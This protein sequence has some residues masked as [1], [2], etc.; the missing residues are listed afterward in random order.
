VGSFE[1]DKDY[2]AYA[3]R[4][5]GA[6]K[7]RVGDLDESERLL[8]ESLEVATVD[9]T[10]AQAM[11]SL[12]TLFSNQGKYEVALSYLVEAILLF[13]ACHDQIGLLAANIAIGTV[14]GRQRNFEEAIPRF[15]EVVRLARK[16]G[17]KSML[18]MALNNLAIASNLVG[19]TGMVKE[20]LEEALTLAKDIGNQRWQ[21]MIE[22]DFGRI[23]LDTGQV[24]MGGELIRSGLQLATKL[25]S[26]PDVLSAL[27]SMAYWQ[28]QN[29]RFVEALVALGY[30]VKSDIATMETQDYAAD[31]WGELS[32][33]LPASFTLQA[34][35]KLRTFNLD[36]ILLMLSRSPK[37]T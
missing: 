32:S 20:Y 19:R 34:Q 37:S 15:R 12:G 36:D 28:A 7:F 25:H 21:A 9:I 18:M 24:Q 6:V 27:V 8:I 29:G 13:E 17:Q 4:S 5:W 33:E 1:V 22:Q 2:L 31:L 35:T 3:L 10:K 14:Y 30:V 26:Q 23:L 11:Q 16:L